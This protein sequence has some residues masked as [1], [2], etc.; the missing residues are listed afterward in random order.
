MTI[1]AIQQMNEER[2]RTGP[3][4]RVI[5]PEERRYPGDDLS[6]LQKLALLQMMNSTLARGAATKLATNEGIQDKPSIVDYHIL[7]ER[8]LAEKLDGQQYHELTY[9]GMKLAQDVLAH[10]CR[11]LDIHVIQQAETTGKGL[12]ARTYFK[13]S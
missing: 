9:E 8:G 5:P 10:L 2:E 3:A 11:Q 1:Q 13:C 4:L 12:D 7:R 6:T